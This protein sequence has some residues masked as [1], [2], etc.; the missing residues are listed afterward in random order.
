MDR[1]L[2]DDVAHKLN[3][4]PVVFRKAN[5]KDR[6]ITANWTVAREI[7]WDRRNKT[8]GA[9]AGPLKRGIGCAVGP[10]AAEVIINARLMSPFHGTGPFWWL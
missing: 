4:D 5:L 2:M 3:M 10:G 6:S 7:G 8:P 1:M 9:G